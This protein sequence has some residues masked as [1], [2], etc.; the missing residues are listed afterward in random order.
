M[1][2]ILNIKLTFTFVIQ[3]YIFDKSLLNEV[4]IRIKYLFFLTDFEKSGL[5]SSVSRY[6]YI[7]CVYVSF[8]QKN[9]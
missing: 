6:R 8:T 3:I 1:Y 4:Y 9:T 2:E 7:L 5:C